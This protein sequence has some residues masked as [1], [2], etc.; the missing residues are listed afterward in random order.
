WLS[1]GA[2]RISNVQLIFPGKDSGVSCVSAHPAP[3]RRAPPGCGP[4][5]RAPRRCGSSEN[6]TGNRTGRK[7][8][9]ENRRSEDLDALA[10]DRSSET[11]PGQ[12]GVSA[13]QHPPGVEE[14]L[15]PLQQH[16]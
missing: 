7:Q 10:A 4:A 9:A 6:G 14:A 3:M 16:L 1:G 2:G 5:F 8:L 13:A 12:L 11:A 15:A